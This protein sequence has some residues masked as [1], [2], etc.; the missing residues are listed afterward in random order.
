MAF[1]PEI[2]TKD[3]TEQ[4]AF[5]VQ[6]IK[7]AIAYLLKNSPFYSRHLSQ[8]RASID[9]FQSM[10]D[11]RKFPT[12]SK[13]D[14]QQ[15]NWDFLCIDKESIA[16]IMSTSGTLGSPVYIALSTADLERLAYNEM[17]SFESMGIIRQDVVQLLLTLD[18]QFMAGIAYYSGLKQIGA[19]VIRSGPG[20]PNM[21]WET[22]RQLSVSSLVA[23][24]SFLVKMLEAAAASKLKVNDL[25]VKKILAIGES[26]R[27]E[28]L[29]PNA[30]AKKILQQWDV[31]LYATYASTEMQTAF[32]EC[33][34]QNGGHHHPELIVVELLDDEGNPVPEGAAGEVTITTLGVEAM[35][36]FRYR[37]GD[38]CKAY[39]EAC[40]CGRKTMRLGPVLGRKQQM[41]K[42]KG[43]TLYAPQLMELL[44]K[45]DFINDYLISISSDNEA[46]DLVCIFIHTDKMSAADCEAMIKPVFQHKWRVI[47]VIQ[48]C[49]AAELHALQFPENTRKPVRIQDLRKNI[50]ISQ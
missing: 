44:N 49:S 5:Q 17:L 15:F 37:T 16:E 4:S 21:Q 40:S 11:M 50:I 7:E 1:I 14:L 9:S 33:T 2:E 18:R 39:Y 23:V 43:T 46:Q 41:I 47:P 29:Q 28:N 48:F 26:L 45:L 12:T 13:T 8:Y 38:I 36:L 19:T 24:P 42:F 35:P 34:A 20:L 31:K 32:T 10:D 30:L 3:L 25:K 6:K 22:M 27:D